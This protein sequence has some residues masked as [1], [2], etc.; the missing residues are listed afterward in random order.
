MPLIEIE[1]EHLVAQVG[2]IVPA[3]MDDEDLRDCMA[4]LCVEGAD[5]REQI[6]NP[7]RAADEG[8]LFRARDALRYRVRDFEACRVEAIRR[9]MRDL[10]DINPER[11]R[12]RLKRSLRWENA[13]ASLRCA[14]LASE[15]QRVRAA[16]HAASVAAGQSRRDLKIE[17]QRAFM[18]AAYEVL[19]HDDLHRIWS[20]VCET[21]PH[22]VRAELRP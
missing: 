22:V 10:P 2:D 15:R 3:E 20:R 9:G 7:V 17:R 11:E 13:Q 14:E 6:G 18:T 5:I 1:S 21:K 8:W 4:M 19:S 16:A 12:A